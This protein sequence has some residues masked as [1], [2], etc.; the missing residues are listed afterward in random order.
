MSFPSVPQRWSRSTLV[1][2]MEKSL[3]LLRQ[4]LGHME[5]GDTGVH[6]AMRRPWAAAS[7]WLSGMSVTVAPPSYKGEL[8]DEAAGTACERDG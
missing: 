2:T 1:T 4:A 8:E 7:Y 6:E 3:S 5:G